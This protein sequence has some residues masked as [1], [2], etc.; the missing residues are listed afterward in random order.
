YVCN[1]K[2]VKKLATKNKG[3]R[4]A[5]SRLKW[6][7][8]RAYA[9]L[10]ATTATMFVGHADATVYTA[11]CTTSTS[12]VTNETALNEGSEISNYRRGEV[13]DVS[14]GAG[15]YS[16][17]YGWGYVVTG[18]M[19]AENRTQ[20]ATGTISNAV[21]I[22]VLADTLWSSE[23][24]FIPRATLNARI[25]NNDSYSYGPLQMTWSC[26]INFDQTTDRPCKNPVN[27]SYSDSGRDNRYT[28]I[29]NRSGGYD[30]LGFIT[31]RPPWAMI[32]SWWTWNH[33]VSTTRN[34]T[35]DTDQA[36]PGRIIMSKYYHIKTTVRAVRD[37]GGGQPAVMTNDS[38]IEVK[39]DCV[40]TT[41]FAL[42]IYPDT[43]DFGTITAG[44]RARVTRTVTWGVTPQQSVPA[45]TTLKVAAVGGDGKEITLGGALV[46]LTDM[47]GNPIPLGAERVIQAANGTINVTLEPTRATPGDYTAG[48]NVTLT[49]P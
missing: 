5:N 36:M 47:A 15:A 14:L 35:V 38:T 25:T 29:Y 17:V 16:W 26:V 3:P 8:L 48:I 11:Q 39:Q 37:N 34:V 22:P 13:G 44:I 20:T 28:S 45:G 1:E 33:D 9:S 18:L 4:T 30:Y 27:G 46:S 31:T 10:A 24:Y 7:T 12:T 42:S 41:R 49:I 32:N 6:L 40:I 23:P 43:I 2:M 21:N 19:F